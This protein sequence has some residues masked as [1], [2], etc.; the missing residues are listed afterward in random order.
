MLF[1]KLVANFIF[2]LTEQKGLGNTERCNGCITC[3]RT[4]KTVSGGLS[5]TVRGREFQK[6]GVECDRRINDGSRR[7]VWDG[8]CRGGGGSRRQR[9]RGRDAE[10]VEVRNA[11]PIRWRHREEWEMGRGFPLRPTIYLFNTPK[12]QRAKPKQYIQ[13]NAKKLLQTT[14]G[15]GRASWAPPAESGT[16]ARRPGRKRISVFFQA[17]DRTHCPHGSAPAAKSCFLDGRARLSQIPHRIAAVRM[18]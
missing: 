13:Y 16:V 3:S 9:R 6:V 14:M 12:Q 8:E 10:G 4:I 7:H 15:Y 1:G 17:F 18:C 2:V 11:Q 5:S